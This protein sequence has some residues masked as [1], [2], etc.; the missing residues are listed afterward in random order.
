MNT[1]TLQDPA[2][3]LPT[4]ALAM[5]VLSPVLRLQA[6]SYRPA[7]SIS[8][9]VHSVQIVHRA[10][11]AVPGRTKATAV[12]INSTSETASSMIPPPPTA[13]CIWIADP[14]MVAEVFR[15][16]PMFPARP[17]LATWKYYRN[18]IG[19]PEGLVLSNGEQWKRVR[20]ASQDLIFKPNHPDVQRKLRDEIV[21]VV[22]QDKGVE[23]HHLAHFK[24]FK[25]VIKESM[26]I[27]PNF[28][29]NSRLIT[30]DTRLPA[31]RSRMCIG[32]RIAE[33]ELHVL[34]GHLL[35]RME[36]VPAAE[37]LQLECTLGIAP[38]GFTLLRP[39]AMGLSAPKC[40]RLD[41]KREV[42]VG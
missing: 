17:V 39:T 4:T 27:L 11:L 30:K 1:N 15:A 8:R 31:T 23:S 6:T 33:M 42:Q 5:S 25:N 21:S 32:R 14:D 2:R 40:R 12:A 22:G 18:K 26:R 7:A 20:A 36:I 9:R 38:I 3:L 28:A 10:L 16:E 19:Y 35:R 34:F 29:S 37:P 13:S 41:L 24:Y